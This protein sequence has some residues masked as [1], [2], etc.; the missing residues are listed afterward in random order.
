MSV[1]HVLILPSL[2]LSSSLSGSDVADHVGTKSKVQC[3]SH[4]DDVYLNSATAPLPVSTT[5]HSDT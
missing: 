2:S 5:W 3:E 1:A 4:Y